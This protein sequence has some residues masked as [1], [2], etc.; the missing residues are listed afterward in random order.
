MPAY[1]Q[2]L[3]QQDVQDLLAYLHTLSRVEKILHPSPKST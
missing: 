3:S 2:T 1:G